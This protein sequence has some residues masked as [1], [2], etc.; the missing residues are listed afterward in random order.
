[1]HGNGQWFTH[2]LDQR[3]S[4]VIEDLKDEQGKPMGTCVVLALGI[5]ER[6]TA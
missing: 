3:G 4:Y 6:A 2:R 5:N 1:M